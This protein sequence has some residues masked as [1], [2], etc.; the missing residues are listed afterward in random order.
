MKLLRLEL[1][2]FEISLFTKWEV[3][4]KAPVHMLTDA[5]FK[6]DAQFGISSTVFLTGHHLD[7]K[8]SY[9]TWALAR[10]FL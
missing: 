2:V 9:H 3:T 7:L 6:K 5:G 1:Y 10:C 8:V 4:W